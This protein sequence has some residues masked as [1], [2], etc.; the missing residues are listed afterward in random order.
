MTSRYPI[1]AEAGRTTTATISA[2]RE[3][4]IQMPCDSGTPSE[5]AIK[6]QV[7]SA[8][9]TAGSTNAATTSANSTAPTGRS[10]SR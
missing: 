6:S 3:V 10:R 4:S 7:G 2:S 1:S 5:K 9:V 8:I